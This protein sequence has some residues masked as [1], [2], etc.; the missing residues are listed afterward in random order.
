MYAHTS[1]IE[2]LRR[3]G[4]TP[5][6]HLYHLTS[7]S[8]TFILVFRRSPLDLNNLPEDFIRDHSKQP[9]DDSSSAASGIYR[10]KKNGSKDER[11]KVYE[12]R[13]CSL[14]FGKSQALGGHMN[15]HRQERETETLNQ[16]R[17]LVFSTDNLLPQPSHQLGGQP[18]AHGSCHYPASFNM[19]SSSLYPPRL[20]S[21]TST[22]ILTPP[23]PPPQPP[24]QQHMYTS[25]P[26]RLYSSQYPN[27][28]TSINNYFVDHY[29]S[30]SSPQLNLQNL[31]CTSLPSPDST[32]N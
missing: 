11:G 30:C 13:F 6:F 15:R 17:Q 2:M 8:Y 18:G 14:K 21:G 31:S 7:I 3:I 27:S 29:V 5:N 26:S 28:Q 22:T 24:H 25:L 12:C 16:A 32:Y 20:F 4:D 9:F 1:M 10:R 23:P 19:G